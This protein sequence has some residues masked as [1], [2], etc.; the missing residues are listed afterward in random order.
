MISDFLSSCIKIRLNSICDSKCPENREQK[1]LLLDTTLDI[2]VASGLGCHAFY[3]FSP[4][5]PSTLWNAFN[6]P[7]FIM[8]TS[9]EWTISN[10]NYFSN[11]LEKCIC[12]LCCRNCCSLFLNKNIEKFPT[13][14]DTG[15]IEIIL[16]VVTRC[17]IIIRDGK[18]ANQSSALYKIARNRQ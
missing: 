10:Q 1:M 5:V 4:S 11:G 16:V 2:S 17:F 15:T 6:F 18:K 13:L 14:L 8:I 9:L 12:W 7:D 3:W